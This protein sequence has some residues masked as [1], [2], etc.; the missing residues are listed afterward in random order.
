MLDIGD[1][2]YLELFERD[3][4][5][6]VAG[7]ASFLHLCLRCDDVEAATESARKAG[8]RVQTEP[9]SPE[10]FK[11]IGVEAKISFIFGPSGEIVEFFQCPQL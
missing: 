4:S 1:G 7:E 2:N 5:K 9:F 6:Q 11:K 10:S 8:A 3:A